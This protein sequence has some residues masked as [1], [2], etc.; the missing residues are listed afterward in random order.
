MTDSFVFEAWPTDF[1]VVMTQAFGVNPDLYRE[2]YRD[3]RGHQGIDFRARRGSRIFAVAAGKIS[4][5]FLDPRPRSLGGHNFG[6]HCRIQH[7]GGYETIYAHMDELLVEAGQEVAAGQQ[8]GVAGSTGYSFAPHLHLH[9]KYRGCVMDPTPFVADLIGR[10]A[11]E[12]E[13]E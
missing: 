5:T 4:M 9:F 11:G 3:V 1:P 2:F 6:V 12:D 8:L 13:E 10:L 7:V